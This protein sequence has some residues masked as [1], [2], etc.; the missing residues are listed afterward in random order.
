M[1][2]TIQTCYSGSPKKLRTYD[3]SSKNTMTYCVKMGVLLKKW[4]PM[5][6]DSST[7]AMK[8]HLSTTT[9]QVSNDKRRDVI[10]A[11]LT[12]CGCEE[13]LAKLQSESHNVVTFYTK[14][15]IILDELDSNIKVTHLPWERSDSLTLGKK[16]VLHR[17]LTNVCNV[18]LSKAVVLPGSELN[19]GYPKAQFLGHYCFSYTWTT[20]QTLRDLLAQSCSCL[21]TIFYYLNV[22][23]T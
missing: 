23:Q 18:W 7:I 2:F 5:A 22:Y 20:S 10:D 3:P 21:L 4:L 17:L 19:Q 13:E 15:Q 14:K 12:I 1:H 9:M 16:S 8:V 6:L 11:Y